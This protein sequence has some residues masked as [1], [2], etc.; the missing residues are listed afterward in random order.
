MQKERVESRAF[1][2]VL[3]VVQ[4]VDIVDLEGAIGKGAGWWVKST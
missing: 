1:L 2:A 3:F 4:C